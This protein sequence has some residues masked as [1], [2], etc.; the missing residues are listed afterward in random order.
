VNRDTEAA[1]S[2]TGRF[3]W[4]AAPVAH[5]DLVD[6]S[7]SVEAGARQYVG[8][9]RCGWESP[10]CAT[11]V[12]ALALVEDHGARSRLRSRRRPD[13]T[14]ATARPGTERSAG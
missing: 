12:H 14:D 8:R 2:L 6:V 4:Q 7:V 11:A 10:A 1:T 9:C 5:H 13:R 3:R